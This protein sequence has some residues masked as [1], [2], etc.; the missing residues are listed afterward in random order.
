MTREPA[1]VVGVVQAVL[2]LVVA[3]G[4]HIDDTQTQAIVAAVT[5]VLALAGAVTVRQRVTPIGRGGGE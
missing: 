3:F 4:V 2:L 5:A 1:L